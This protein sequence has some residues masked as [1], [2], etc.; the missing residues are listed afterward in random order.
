M[1]EKPVP[2]DPDESPALNDLIGITEGAFDTADPVSLGRSLFRA[3]G[4]AAR[5]PI[6]A[7]PAWLRY[8]VGL[9][10]VGTNLATRLVGIELP[11]VAE[12]EPRDAI[13]LKNE[14]VEKGGKAVFTRP[15]GEVWHYTQTRKYCP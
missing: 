3:V 7:T 2:G 4:R 6:H 1:P 12:P 11:G 13:Y 15:K 8:G 10:M 9:G 14:L 5:R